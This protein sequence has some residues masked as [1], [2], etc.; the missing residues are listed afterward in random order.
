MV[1]CKYIQW[2]NNKYLSGHCLFPFSYSEIWLLFL[3]DGKDIRFHVFSYFFVCLDYWCLFNHQW[4]IL[5]EVMFNFFLSIILNFLNRVLKR[6][7]RIF[8]GFHWARSVQSISPSLCVSVR[9]FSP[10][11]RNQ[12]K[13]NHSTYHQNLCIFNHSSWLD[14]GL[15]ILHT[16]DTKSLKWCV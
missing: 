11:G 13:A 16:G 12:L 5:L 15:I 14:P 1:F 3:F 8:S 9:L 7:N 4:K 6:E 2:K 10:R